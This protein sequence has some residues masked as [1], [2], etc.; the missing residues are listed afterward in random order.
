MRLTRSDPV[1]LRHSGIGVH[2]DRRQGNWQQVFDVFLAIHFP[3]VV[4]PLHAFTGYHHRLHPCHHH[5]L[6]GGPAAQSQVGTASVSGRT[7]RTTDRRIVGDSHRNSVGVHV[8]G[9]GPFEETPR[10]LQ[11]IEPVVIDQRGP[12]Y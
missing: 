10:L 8:Q 11:T 5:I 9:H 2:P 6:P 7:P 3:V 4:D 1:I 12:D